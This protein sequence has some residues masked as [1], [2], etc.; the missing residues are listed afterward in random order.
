MSARKKSTKKRAGSPRGRQLAAEAL[1]ELV[2]DWARRLRAHAGPEAL[3]RLEKAAATLTGE[4]M[5]IEH[6][7]LQAMLI[8]DEL[9]RATLGR[10]IR[11]F[12]GALDV[13]AKELHMVT[14]FPEFL[15]LLDASDQ[16]EDIITNGNNGPAALAAKLTVL[17]GAFGV[18]ATNPKTP[19]GRKLV[20]TAQAQFREVWDKHRE[21]VENPPR[22]E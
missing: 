15:R 11:T 18:P 12:D 6:R 2:I 3:R 4:D 21:R 9:Q 20:E 13:T 1:A 10:R 16:A 19:G 8:L 22:A 7:R 5:G 17:V 14:G